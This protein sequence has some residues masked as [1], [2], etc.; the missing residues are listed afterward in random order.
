MKKKRNM[1]KFKFIALSSLIVFNVWGQTGKTPL[2]VSGKVFHDANANGVMDSGEKPMDKIEVSNGAD[3]V[4]TKSDGVFRF[5]THPVIPTRIFI[6]EPKGWKATTDFSFLA[7]KNGKEIMFGL[8]E[9]KAGKKFSFIDGGDIQ[10]DF[11]KSP[12]QLIGDLEFLQE[13]QKQR[14]AVFSLWPGDLTPYGK[15]YNLK[16]L[17]DKYRAMNLRFYPVFGGHDAIA[18]RKKPVKTAAYLEMIGPLAYSWNYGNLHFI[19]M[20][21]EIGWLTNEQKKMQMQWLKK[22]LLL[23]PENTRIVLVTHIPHV[24]LNKLLNLM[25]A[26]NHRLVAIFRA[27]THCHNLQYHNGVPELC[28]APWRGGEWGAFTKRS[29]FITYDKGKLSSYIRVLGQ[30]ESITI[31][32]PVKE[33]MQGKEFLIAANIY[34]SEK[35]VDAVNWTI[36]HEG[37]TVSSGKLKQKSDWTWSDEIPSTLSPG[38][39][40]IKITAQSGKSQWSAEKVFETTSGVP[41]SLN[42]DWIHSTGNNLFYLSAPVIDKDGNSVFLGLRDG[43][44]GT[45][46][47]GVVRLDLSSGKQIWRTPTADDINSTVTLSGDSVYA[48]S[49]EGLLFRMKKSNGKIVWKKNIYEGLK[50]RKLGWRLMLAPL[51]S[52]KGKIYTFAVISGTK[53]LAC[54]YDAESGK[55]EWT[56]IIKERGTAY[57]SGGL[58]LSGD[59]LY[60][61]QTN[62]IGALDAKTGETKWT[63]K[64]VKARAIGTPYVHNNSVYFLFANYVYCVNTKNDKLKWRSSNVGGFKAMG[65]VVYSKGKVIVPHGITITAVDEATGKLVWKFKTPNPGGLQGTNKQGIRNMSTPAVF[66]NNVY[67]GGDNGIMYVVDLQT[68]KLQDHYE[69]GVPVKSALAVSGE[70]LVFSAYDGNIYCFNLDNVKDR[71]VSKKSQPVSKKSQPVSKKSQ[72]DAKK[73]DKTPENITTEKTVFSPA[74]PYKTDE[75]TLTLLHFDEGEGTVAQDAS[76]RGNNADLEGSPNEPTWYKPGRFGA[77]LA[78]DGKN[79][80]EDGDK[81][82]DADGLILQKGGSIDPDGSGFTVELWVNHKNLIG[83][84][85]YLASAGNSVGRYVFQSVG[86]GVEIMFLVDKEKWSR[87]HVTNVLTVG[88]WHHVAFTYDKK[89]LRVYID[90]VEKERVPAEG[91]IPGGSRNH[92]TCIGHDWDRNPNSIRSFAGMIDELRVSNIARTTFPEGPYSEASKKD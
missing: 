24:I 74:A 25:K 34:D 67:V 13:M 1:S 5:K 41:S 77:C 21:S 90:G 6:T 85:Y 65:S 14:K 79:A 18:H 73:V 66:K 88:V 56:K 15:K 30:K 2:M 8:T 23:L 22:H 40:N 29:R 61:G 37:K 48:I 47:A 53:G 42:L 84:Q 91:K 69:I 62:T 49:N 31:L 10:Y 4:L 68:G 19:G 59:T 12:K 60:Y 89:F 44:L 63:Q 20:V 55:R 50:V 51:T 72:S 82:G 11:I 52:G 81:K 92:S 70:K 57:Q 28:S 86:N 54:C 7:Q 3:I 26:K 75:Y 43:Q 38:K 83:K 33:T 27:H 87:V 80:D 76:G 36:T 35:I 9:D 78:L 17:K 71:P 58:A 32:S 64:T 39:Y 16:F 45:K 46:K